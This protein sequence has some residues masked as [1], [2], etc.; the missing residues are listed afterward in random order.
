MPA[1]SPD[2]GA[3]AW[4]IEDP[5]SGCMMQGVTQTSGTGQEVDSYHSKLQGIHTLLLA[6]LVVCSFFDIVNGAVT[7]GCDS[8]TSLNCSS[9]DLLKV[10]QHFLPVDQYMQFS[11]SAPTFLFAFSF[12]MLVD[13]WIIMPAMKHSRTLHS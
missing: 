7:V 4:V 13:T 9:A 3:A 11:A 12:S 5:Q 6:L 8:A 1:L 2:L 10:S